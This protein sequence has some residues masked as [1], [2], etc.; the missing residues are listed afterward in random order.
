M[1]QPSQ[2]GPRSRHSRREASPSTMNAPFG[3]PMSKAMPAAIGLIDGSDRLASDIQ[4]ETGVLREFTQLD[5]GLSDGE[6]LSQS[7]DER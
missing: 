2:S 5:F 6:H 7:F 1:G 4:F 3:V